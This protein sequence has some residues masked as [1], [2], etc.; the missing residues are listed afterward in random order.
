MMDEGV[1]AVMNEVVIGVTDEAMPV[2]G[3]EAAAG[4]D[5]KVPVCKDTGISVA[6]K[7]MGVVVIVV[8]GRVSVVALVV[9]EAAFVDVTVIV[10]VLVGEAIAGSTETHE[11]TREA[12][13]DKGI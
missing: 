2:V 3:E 10:E 5:E 11:V 12:V 8:E 13:V 9:D 6:D 7:A 1:A 4:L